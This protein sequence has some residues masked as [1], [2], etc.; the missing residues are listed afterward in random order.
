MVKE[1]DIFNAVVMDKIGVTV[2]TVAFTKAKIIKYAPEI[3]RIQVALEKDSK[4]VFEPVYTKYP[5]ENDDI[6]VCMNHTPTL[7][8]LVIV[9]TGDYDF[10][11]ATK[12]YL[13]KITPSYRA[14]ELHYAFNN[15]MVTKATDQ[16][17]RHDVVKVANEVANVKRIYDYRMFIST[18]HL[19]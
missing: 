16:A 13:Y 7:L 15:A 2:R 5:V 8:R 14:V 4:L 19:R 12:K 18:A 9:D 17:F 3:N 10:I 6:C 11:K 1:G